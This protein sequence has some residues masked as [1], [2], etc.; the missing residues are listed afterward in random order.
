MTQTSTIYDSERSQW[1]AIIHLVSNGEF[2]FIALDRYSCTAELI[3]CCRKALA[4]FDHINEPDRKTHAEIMGTAMELLKTSYGLNAPPGWYPVMKQLRGVDA[5]LR[6]P[7]GRTEYDLSYQPEDILSDSFSPLHFFEAELKPFRE[8]IVKAAI[9]HGTPKAFAD[10]AVF[11]DAVIA[12]T[13][14]GDTDVLMTVRNKMH[15]GSFRAG[16]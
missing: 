15:K 7:S 3:D 8:R 13:G 5:S 9:T 12:E 10:G 14:A 6:N 2:N 4:R 1:K 16:R 11:L